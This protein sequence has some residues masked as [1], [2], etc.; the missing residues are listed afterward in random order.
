MSYYC[1]CDCKET[2]VIV[3]D[4]HN[5]WPGVANGSL[6][7]CANCNGIFDGNKLHQQ[8]RD[9]KSENEEVRKNWTDCARLSMYDTLK[10]VREIADLEDENKKLENVLKQAHIISI[11][12]QNDVYI[13]Q[14][15]YND[16]KKKKE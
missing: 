6:E 4:D 3:V 2:M 15:A 10:A 9:L 13:L 7:V 14:K 11:E 16:R 5:Q 1:S 12:L 8:I